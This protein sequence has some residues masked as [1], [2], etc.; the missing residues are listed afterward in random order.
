MAD[1]IIFSNVERQYQRLEQAHILLVKEGILQPGCR[2]LFFSS[3]SVWDGAAEKEIKD[4]KAVFLIWQGKV[5]PNAFS[6]EAE[7]ILRKNRI[8]YGIFSSTLNEIEAARD[9]SAE[10]IALVSR[11]L[12]YSGQANYRSLWLWLD[13]RFRGT[14]QTIAP[15]VKLP[16]YG[17]ITRPEGQVKSRIDSKQ[18]EDVADLAAA[19]R[20]T[21]EHN[22]EDHNATDKK[23]RV[24]ILF[25]RENWFWQDTKYLWVLIDALE[26]RGMEVLPIYSLWSDNAA[27]EAAGVSKA[28]QAL[29]YRDGKCLI[30]ALVNTFKVEMTRSSGND[31][32]FLKKLNVPVL[33]G[34]NLLGD[35]QRW[36]DS[37]IG[38]D[39][40][41]LSCNVVEPEFDGVIHELPLSTKEYG[42][43]GG[44]YYAPIPERI[45]KYADK[46]KKWALLAHKTNAEK[47]VAIIFHNYPPTNDS[48]GSAQGLDSFASVIALLAA[49]KEAGYQVEKVPEDTADLCQTITSGITN[50]RRFL[51][52]EQ[53][54]KALAAVPQEKYG[55]WFE[56]QDLFLQSEMEEE[57]GPAPG[58]VF[59]HEGRLLI[60][61]IPNGNIYIGMQPPRGF[62]EDPGK[63]IH[64]PTCPPPHHYL[65]FYQWLREDW[66]ADAV[67]HVGTH[68]SLEWLPGKN[69]GLSAKCY[70]DAALGDLPDIYPYY[71]TIVGEGIQAKRRGAACLIGHLNP[72][73][74]HADTY[75][76]LAELEKMLDEYSHYKVQQPGAEETIKNRI[77][78]K[79]KEMHLE[80]DIPK[81]DISDDAYILKIHTYVE[82]LKHM[83]IRTGLHILGKAPEGDTLTEYILVLTRVENGDIPSLPKTIAAAWGC[84]YYQLEQDSGC[85]LANGEN[86]AALLDKIWRICTAIVE[87]LRA[88][89]FAAAAIEDLFSLP[90]CED[91]PFT[92]ELRQDLRQVAVFICTVIA[93]NLALTK[94]EITNTL[95]ALNG[96]YIEPGPGGAPTS[97]RVDI[98]PTGRNFYGVD[99]MALPTPTAWEL[100]KELAEQAVS[101]F[102][103]EEGHYPESIGI[104]LWS[105]SNMRSHGQCIAEVLYLMGIRPVWQRGSQRICGLEVIPLTELQRP[106]IDVTMRISGLFR[107]SLS[108]AAELLEKAVN[109]AAVQEETPE[110]NFIRKHIEEDTDDL[111]EEGLTKEEA[112]RQASYRIF[113][114]PPGSYGAG[115]AHM[116]EEKNWETVHDLGDVYV[117][118]G[119]HVYGKKEEGQ[120]LPKIFRRR[121]QGIEL[122]IK[123]IDN[124]EVHLLNSDDFNAYCGGMN[125]AVQS[126]RGKMPRCYIGDSADRACAETRSL[127]EEFRRVF[128]GESMNPKYIQGMKQHGYKGASD[129]ANLVVHAFGWDAT[130]SVMENWMYEGFAKKLALDQEI[131]DWM[132]EVNPWALHRMTAKL[133]EAEQRNMWE[134]Q[135][136]T[137]AQLKQL[138]MEIEGEIEDRSDEK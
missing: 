98:L 67:I 58:D 104:I 60:P 46:V 137:L 68:G 30:H 126:I 73:T 117:R 36:W 16:W 61:G 54:K 95:R 114:C 132:R 116:L 74:S 56:Q 93:P 112:I 10:E 77:L 115:V 113:G 1:I 106:R 7:K 134:A 51:T 13:Q 119:A 108:A 103:R 35:Y 99:P 105:D 96:E 9:V 111:M 97:G 84:D 37:Y 118:W 15:P 17:V 63:I 102:I 107:D 62:G 31:P 64:S 28:V 83:Q 65:A 41:E 86:G 44:V 120:F 49:M 125:A 121:L 48:I 80:E 79:I 89:A 8:P 122:T 75:E 11:Y 101:R 6:E 14:K 42:E 18:E 45:K 39:P 55:A 92:D 130:S 47:R 81:D 131:Q 66:K 23:I 19:N 24:G 33:Q 38:M 69:A 110:D 82:R 124:H 123:N 59:Q 2:S 91:V 88:D 72:P 53:M 3:S 138:Y 127:G 40:V 25:S 43:D 50:D 57:W 87:K 90:E 27:E 4:A 20:N 26:N 76:D 34:Y 71:V 128:R 70:P 133:L 32:E 100:G 52:E 135:P 21:T 29:F 94:Q 136:E 129:L 109:L 5:F 22:T 12:S 85:I 78:T